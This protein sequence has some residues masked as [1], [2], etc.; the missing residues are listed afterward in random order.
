MVKITKTFISKLVKDPQTILESLTDDEIAGILQKASY[1]YYNTDTPLF[2]DNTFDLIQEY[3]EKRCPDHPILKNIGAAVTDSKKEEL[4]FYMG[5]LDKIKT[6]QKYFEKWMS[7]YTCS[8]MISDKLDGNSGLFHVNKNG[9][10]S[11]FTRG[12]GTIGQNVTH[13]KGFVRHLP[14]HQMTKDI[15]VRGEFIIS[16]TDF[17]KLRA[18]GAN[19][20]NMVAG[21]LNAKIPDMEV[22]QH[23]Q[24]IAYEVIHPRLTPEK[25]FEFL[26]EHGFKSA[27]HTLVSDKVLSLDKLSS[28]LLE[29]RKTSE[30]EIDGIVVYHNELHQRIKEN[31][32]YAFAFKNVQT[33]DRTEVIVAKVEWNMSKDGYMKPVVIFNPVPLSGVTVQRATGF[34]AKFIRDNKI[35]PGSKIVVMRSG[36][37]IPYI[38]D[39]ITES[40]TGEP[41]MPEVAYEWTST[42]VDI[43]VDKK[44]TNASDELMLKNLQHFF[45]KVDFQGVS[46]ATIKKLYAAGFTTVRAIFDIKKTDLL[47]IDGFKEKSSEKLLAALAEKKDGISCITLMEASNA[48]GRGFGAKKLELILQGIPD[49]LVKRYVPT[50]E[51]LVKIKGVEK[52]TAQTFVGNLPDFFKFLKDNKL[53]CA[54]EDTVT[55][56]LLTEPVSDKLNGIVV[57]FTGFRDK[58]LEEFVKSNGGTVSGTVNKKTTLLVVKEMKEKE[59]GKVLE[60]QALGIKIVTLAVFKAQIGF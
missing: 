29:R 54:A 31:P 15:A 39:I 44:D 45:N 59:S 20:R 60:A 51:E 23:V 19:A 40:G 3:L 22:A 55:T 33:M 17:E 47:K 1:Q 18:K 43:F 52:K 36:D 53:V 50:V 11:L 6:D 48:L 9:Q 13:L 30:F 37:V 46:S 7:T 10:V 21:I 38:T 25:Q 14:S 56:A 49:I 32:K 41:Q 34:N 4:P 35:G 58:T 16:K 57:V 8:Y 26:K 27:W 12:D 42:G 24:F 28:V 2:S 5:S